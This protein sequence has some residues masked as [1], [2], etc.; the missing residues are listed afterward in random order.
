MIMRYIISLAAAALLSFS[1]AGQANE[2][3]ENAEQAPANNAYTFNF[4]DPN[5]WMQMGGAAP[6]A[7]VTGLQF[8][9]AHPADWM[10]IVDPKTHHAMHAMFANPATYTQFMQPQFYMEFMKPENMMAWMNPASYQVMMDP[11]T[12]TWWMNPQAYEHAFNPAM[13]QAAMNP[14][15]YMVYAN[16]ATYMAWAGTG[17]CD[18]KDGKQ[19]QGWFGYSC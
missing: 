3:S 16:P 10:K 18:P 17:T 7:P 6:A 1:I 5:T 9:A 11:Q 14:A 12:M 15:N 19:N 13:Y 4:F 2:A 8:N